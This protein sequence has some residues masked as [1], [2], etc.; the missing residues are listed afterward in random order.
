LRIGLVAGETSGDMLGAGLIQAIRARIPD[1]VFEGVAGP[2]MVAAGC[3]LLYPAERLAVMGLVEVLGRYRELHAMRADLVR[4]FHSDPPDVFVGIDAPEFNLGL[5][6]RLKSAG[7]R[8]AHY[9]SPQVWAWRR[10]RLRTIARSAD[11]ILTLFPFEAAFYE[12]HGVPVS[13][14]GH[15]LADAI[16]SEIDRDA[17]RSALA[18][19]AEGE[20]IALMP[21]SR[22]SEVRRLG[23]IF[24]RTARWCLER[25]PGLRFAVPL[26]DGGTR[27][28]FE[29]ALAREPGLPLTVFE[30]RSL[31]VMAAADAVLL[32][33]GTATLEAMLLK[34]PMVVAYRMAAMTH[35]LAK[36]LVYIDRFSIPNLLAGER[37]VP[38]FIQN[39]ARPEALGAAL[40]GYLDDPARAAAVHDRFSALHESLRRDANERAAD[41][42]LGLAR[43]AGA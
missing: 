37:I 22:G 28:L 16:A 35:W 21:G 11:L 14:V 10:R 18:L 19:P 30:G 29:R 25:R 32:A 43:R 38:E 9:V 1:A 8:T 23:E 13:F 2:R 15:P 42:V 4:H 33:S 41:A 12:E 6:A 3:R 5:E 17:A 39:A 7:I 34:R 20:L 40:L 36:R 31:E 27:E 26:V 24:V